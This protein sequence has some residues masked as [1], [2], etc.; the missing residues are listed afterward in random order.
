MAHLE[1]RP[2]RTRDPAPVPS[3][4]LPLPHQGVTGVLIDDVTAYAALTARDDEQ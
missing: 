1:V 2:S 3:S 4:S